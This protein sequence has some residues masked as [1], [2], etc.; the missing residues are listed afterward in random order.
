MMVVPFQ[1]RVL[2]VTISRNYIYIYPRMSAGRVD[3]IASA[4]RYDAVSTS[5][6]FGS[7][8]S[9]VGVCRYLLTTSLK[10]MSIILVSRRPYA[11]V[12]LS[13]PVGC[14]ETPQWMKFH[15]ACSWHCAPSEA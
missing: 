11:C 10:L 8:F 3:G 1:C 6:I 14:H 7:S 12:H 2:L 13:G 9:N 4:N 15:K 5:T